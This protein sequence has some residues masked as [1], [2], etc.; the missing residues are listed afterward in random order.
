MPASLPLITFAYCSLARKL[1]RSLP[2]AKSNP[3]P[4]ALQLQRLRRAESEPSLHAPTHGDGEAERGVLCS[5]EAGGGG[6][7]STA[8]SLPGDDDHDNNDDRDDND[9]HDDG[10]GGKKSRSA[11][12]RRMLEMRRDVEDRVAFFKGMVRECTEEVCVLRLIVGPNC[13]IPCLRIERPRFC[14]S[15]LRRHLVAFFFLCLVALG[16]KE[17]SREMRIQRT[18]RAKK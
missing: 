5:A 15:F 12:A 13:V 9:D 1:G 11:S 8:G 4:C 10:T 6:D 3:S 2:L 7:A 16:T 14:T 18:S 17:V